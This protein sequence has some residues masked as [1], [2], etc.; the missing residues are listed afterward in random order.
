VSDAGQADLG[1]GVESID[2]L[3]E[4]SLNDL[5]VRIEKQGVTSIG[6]LP[7]AVVRVSKATV[8]RGDHASLRKGRLHELACTIGRTVVDDDHL[9]RSR[10]GV[11]IDGR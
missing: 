9:E 8:G 7:P 2:Q 5:S 3:T 11:R 4:R 6:A 10:A 1:P